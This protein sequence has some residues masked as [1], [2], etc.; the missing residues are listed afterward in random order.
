[1]AVIELL[2]LAMLP[3]LQEVEGAKAC[4]SVQNTASALSDRLT[5]HA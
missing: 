3:C 1:M 5:S 4:V 2:T